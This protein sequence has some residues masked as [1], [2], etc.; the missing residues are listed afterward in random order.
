MMLV[1]VSKM[2]SILNKGVV[3]D[4]ALYILVGICFYLSIFTFLSVFYDLMFCVTISSL[5]SLILLGYTEFLP[6]DNSQNL[7]SGFSL[8]VSENKYIITSIKCIVNFLYSVLKYIYSKLDAKFFIKLFIILLSLFINCELINLDGGD[9]DSD[10][11]NN[12][13]N[14]GKGKELDTSPISENKTEEVS[15]E[16]L[17]KE[18]EALRKRGEQSV[19]ERLAEM[20]GQMN[21]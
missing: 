18:Q 3:T 12:N 9:D 5:F 8:G 20:Y 7:I 13:K 11:D 15:D 14:K 21:I 6:K 1:R 16:K 19:T 10:T 2:I 17:K 4:Y